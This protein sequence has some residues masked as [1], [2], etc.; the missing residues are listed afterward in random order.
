MQSTV[1][2]KWNNRLPYNYQ[3]GS[4]M[5]I[6]IWTL[7]VLLQWYKYNN[8]DMPSYLKIKTIALSVHCID[9]WIPLSIE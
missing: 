3:H 6:I 4:C 5:L 1:G 7:L 8:T 2:F 9:I